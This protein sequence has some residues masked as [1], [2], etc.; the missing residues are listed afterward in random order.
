MLLP[1]VNRLLHWMVTGLMTTV[2]SLMILSKGASL[3]DLGILGATTSIIVVVLEFPSGILSDVIGRKR[4]YLIS[5]AFSLVA[6]IV[7][8]QTAGFAPLLA[9]FALYAASRA[10]SS[11]SIEAVYIND[12]IRERGKEN[13]HKLMSA[14]SAGETIGL[15]GGALLGGFLPIL[16]DKFRPDANRY[17]SILAAQIL[18][19]AV[20]GLMTM[21]TTKK[22]EKPAEPPQTFGAY[23]ADVFGIIRRSRV[24]GLMLA[25]AIAWG[26]AFAGIEVYWQPRL[27]D[28]LGS[29][30]QTWIFGIINSGYFAASLIGVLLVG[31]ILSKRK[32]SHL[33]SLFIL[34]LVMAAF[35]FL[36][37]VQTATVSFA[38]VYLTMFLF[39]GMANVPEGTVFN[40]E[41]PE[42]KRSSML[43]LASLAL[44]LGGAAGSLLF[45]ALVTKIFIPGIW[46]MAGGILAVSAFFFLAAGHYAGA[47]KRYD[48]SRSTS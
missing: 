47:I 12:F 36:L 39:N 32:I 9:G 7:L 20:L 4:I 5:I 16:W 40:A 26:F 34:R 21:L 38:F 18:I 37:A 27:K 15:A 25:S 14:M 8:M 2:M 31:I 41:I 23:I 1:F 45:A 48:S 35:I 30:T 17:N 28:I 46:M 42:A 29:D 44:Q 19:L 11:G 43:S 3:G 13:L 10:F 22:D 24:L 33:Y 6:R